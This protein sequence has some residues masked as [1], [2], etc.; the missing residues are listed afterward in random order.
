MDTHQIEMLNPI[1]E[2]QNINET[3]P[4]LIL[5]DLFG[6]MEDISY[7]L[8]DAQRANALNK[9]SAYDFYTLKHKYIQTR[10][11]FIVSGVVCFFDF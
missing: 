8:V 7:S 2:F 4:R 11:W 10:N 3:T 1:E 5:D 9:E 6:K